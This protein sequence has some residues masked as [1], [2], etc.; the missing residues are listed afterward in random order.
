MPHRLIWHSVPILVFTDARVTI[1]FYARL[2]FDLYADSPDYLIVRR[3]GVELQ[4][5]RVPHGEV[6]GPVRCY[7]RSPNLLALRSEF[8]AA[9]GVGMSPVTTRY[10]MQEFEIVDP[11]GNMLRFGQPAND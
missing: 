9:E 8:E 10:R 6:Q 2:G 11:D 3:D 4:F 7:L 1:D 5:A